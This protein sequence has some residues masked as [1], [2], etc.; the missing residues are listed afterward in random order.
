MEFAKI[1]TPRE[2][3]D[4]IDFVSAAGFVKVPKVK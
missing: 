3:A 2:L 4:T 1:M